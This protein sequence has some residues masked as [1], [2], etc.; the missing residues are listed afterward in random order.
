MSFL[1]LFTGEPTDLLKRFFWATMVITAVFFALVVRFWYLQIARGEHF[2][3]LS[4]NNRVRVLDIPPSRGIIFDR[5]GMMLVSSRPAFNLYV[6]PD[7][8]QDWKVLKGRLSKLLELDPEQLEQ[9]YGDSRSGP[10]KPI[11]L[12]LDL[13][14]DELGLLETY[15]YLLPGIYIEVSPQRN[16]PLG[17]VAPHTIGYL[18]EITQKQLKSGEYPQQRL[19]DMIGQWGLELQWQTDL[20]GSKGGRY[21]EVDALGQEIRPLYAKDSAAGNNVITTL[22]WKLQQ[23]AQEA[24][25]NRA[26][27]V[28]ALRPSTGE[29]LAL[30]SAPPFD[31]TTFSRRLST[32]EWNAL[33]NDPSKPMQ[34]R[35]IQGQYPP[36]STYKIVTAL[37]A[38]EEKVITPETAFYCSGGLPFGNRVF[39]CWRKGGHGQVNLHKAIVQ[40]CDVY[41]YQVGQRLGVDRLAHYARLFGLGRP[42]GVSLLHEKKGLIP[43]SAW[44]QDRFK[45][46]WQPGETL[47][48]AIGQGYDLVTPIQM[49]VLTAAVANGGTV[50]RP[51]LVKR[52]VSPQGSVIKEFQP[53]ITSKALVSPE[54]L[55]LV[56]QGLS[57][58]VN[59]PGGTGAASRLP[60]VL[61]AGKTGTAQVITLG[62]KA[63]SGSSR[64]HAWFVAYAP[65]ENPEIAVAVLVEHGGHGGEAAAPI[66][67]KLFEAH[68]SLPPRGSKPPREVQGETPVPEEAPSG[69]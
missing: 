9:R 58:V 27:A 43:T 54:S 52:L 69:D 65:V 20:G 18:S 12:K 66:A 35:V 57:G 19:G 67:R 50:Y 59:E 14:R 40:S 36:G 60:G 56:R 68:F 15:K 13:S 3:Q 53:V 39:H 32:Q 10:L 62:K 22:D 64:D 48:I 16:Y 51:L 49:A 17:I 11:P 37:A 44:K 41:F 23:A 47:S 30:A 8:V 33:Q 42:T 4:E 63:V 7:D 46:P 55:L 38:L 6:I 26:G 61:A 31:P 2:R 25:K 1:N 5:N 29:V 24:L 28:V 21:L 34:N 45:I